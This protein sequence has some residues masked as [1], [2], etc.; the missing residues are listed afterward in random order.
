MQMKESESIIPVTDLKE[1]T[2][3]FADNTQG[4]PWQSTGCTATEDG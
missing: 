3:T 4:V 1:V 2:I